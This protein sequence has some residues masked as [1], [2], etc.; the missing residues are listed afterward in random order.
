MTSF[1]PLSPANGGGLTTV[2]IFVRGSGIGGGDVETDTDVIWDGSL[3]ALA[4]ASTMVWVGNI[5]WG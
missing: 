2:R 5:V 3:E 4:A 1:D